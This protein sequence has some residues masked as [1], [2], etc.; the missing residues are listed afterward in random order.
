MTPRVRRWRTSA[1]VSISLMTGMLFLARKSS[2]SASE[3]QLLATGENSRTT[4]PS[5]NGLPAS[6]SSCVRAVVADLRVREDDDLAGIG[7][8]GENF[9]ISGDGGI[10]N[11]LAVSFRAR[12]KTTALEDCSVL[13]GEDRWIQFLRGSSRWGVTLISPHLGGRS[14]LCLGSACHFHS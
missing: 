12:T 5:I 13:Q 3:R 9:L 10:E 1:R 8:I 11:D 4:R 7:R 14:G 2:A 6:L